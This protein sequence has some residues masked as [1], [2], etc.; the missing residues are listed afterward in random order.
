MTAVPVVL[1]A[2]AMAAL[3]AISAGW[4]MRLLL[5]IVIGVCVFFIVYIREREIGLRHRLELDRAQ[6]AQEEKMIG[7][8]S[9][10]RHQWMNELQLLYG[11]LQL[12]KWDK[13]KP[14][15]ERIKAKALQESYVSRLGVAEL[16]TFLLTFES[17]GKSMTLDVELSEEVNLRKLG[18]E[19]DRLADCFRH[20]VAS[21]DA[22]ALATADG[23]NGLS[24]EITRL[25]RELAVEFVFSGSYDKDALQLAVERILQR[26]ADAV[27]LEEDEY[28]EQR[29][30][31]ALR[32]SFPIGEDI[33]NVC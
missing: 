16:A 3:I 19:A 4:A 2:V 30:T 27:E 5:G 9:H 12:K 29:V 8:L 23:S 21:F 11:Y 20:L 10:A 25:E 17:G 31:V 33:R 22:H 28:D 26:Y 6:A 32:A 1:A 18:L 24:V 15:M 14:A 7:V 13:L